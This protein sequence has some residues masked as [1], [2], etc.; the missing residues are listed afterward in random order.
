M[1]QPDP[2]ILAILVCDLVVEDKRS[3]NK[4]LVNMFNAI[5]CPRLPARHDRL[6]VFV[7]MT[8]GRGKVPVHLELIGPD[9]ATVLR[10]DG[11]G[12]F[13]DPLTA[14]DL[15]FELRG[16]VFPVAGMYRFQ[17]TAGQGAIADRPF[18]VVLPS[19]PGESS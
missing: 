6:V 15:V 18:S 13:A 19:T 16:V 17:V 14:H 5:L 1:A 7:Q 8:N 2:K 11:E 4:S 3:G 12:T 9:N 10:L